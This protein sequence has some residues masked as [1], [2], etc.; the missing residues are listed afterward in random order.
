MELG[1]AVFGNSR[2]KY[3]IEQVTGFEDEIARLFA[4][5]CPYDS[6]GLE[7]D[8]HIFSVFPYYWGDE[9]IFATKPNF[10][11]KPTGFSIQWYKYPLRDSYTSQNITLNEFREIITQ[12]LDSVPVSKSRM[13]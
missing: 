2:G 6:A 8:N 1:N 3:P 7:F 13:L 12:C 5:I 9:K 4:V 11:F 10:L